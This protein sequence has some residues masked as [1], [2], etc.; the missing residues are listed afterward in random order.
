MIS[1]SFGSATRHVSLKSTT[2]R[3]RARMTRPTTTPTSDVNRAANI[4]SSPSRRMRLSLHRA[5]HH[6][7]GR[8]V[9]HNHHTGAA[10]DRLLGVGGVGVEGFAAATDG[11]HHLTEVSGPDGPGHPANL[12]DHPL[13]IHRRTPHSQ[14]RTL[15]G[16]SPVT[17]RPQWHS[18]P[19]GACDRGARGAGDGWRG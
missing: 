11:D 17:G 8:E 12:P 19:G 7:A 9:L 10:P 13:V 16:G 4:G 3:T 6:G 5:D 14:Q 1:A 15:S 2:T 18:G